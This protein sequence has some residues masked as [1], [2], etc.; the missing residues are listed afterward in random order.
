M[1]NIDDVAKLAGVSTATV[2]AVLNGQDIVKPKTRKKVFEAI[3]ALNYQPNLYAR[4]LARGRSAMLGVIISDI[5]NPFF[6]EIA[7]RVQTEALLRSYQCLISAT[8]FS[9]D[10][11]TQAVH[12]MMGMRVDGLIIVTSEMHDSISDVLRS[13]RVPVVFEDVGTVDETIANLRIDYEGGIHAAVTALVERG[14]KRLLFAEN[15]PDI[16]EPERWLSHR[17]RADAFRNALKRFPDVH[18][19]FLD[20]PGPAFQAGLKGAR[21][22][23]KNFAVTGV[24]VNA[25]PVAFGFLRGFLEAGKRVPEDI[26]LVGFDDH[27]AC[28]YTTPSLTSV[29]VSRETIGVLA[30]KTI[31]DMIDNGKSG[32]EINI[33]TRL[34]FRQSVA[35]VGKNVKKES[36]IGDTTTFSGRRSRANSGGRRKSNG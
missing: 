18:A 29:S 2:S 6:A 19:D 14:H 33:P 17:L 21:E 30:V 27:P 20:C 35:S 7:Q 23:L 25:D 24:V 36:A 28:E 9:V 26:S 5:G 34:V 16:V 8:Q 32:R 13:R 22:V 10:R 1:A 31:L 12:H 11:L 3:E 4:T 15:H